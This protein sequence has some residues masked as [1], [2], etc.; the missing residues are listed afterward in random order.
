M[1]TGPGQWSVRQHQTG[2]PAE[3]EKGES[4][5]RGTKRRYVQADALLSPP[6]L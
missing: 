5:I 4:E 6:R 1:V 3:Q 2:A